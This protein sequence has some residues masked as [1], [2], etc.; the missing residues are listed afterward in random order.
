MTETEV[1]TAFLSRKRAETLN[2]KSDS[3]QL[4]WGETVIAE[5]EGKRLRLVSQ[6]GDTGAER[7]KDV[8]TY[9]ILRKIQEDSLVQRV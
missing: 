5:W 2:L 3:G 7:C 9:L 1:M 6:N 4:H 8:L